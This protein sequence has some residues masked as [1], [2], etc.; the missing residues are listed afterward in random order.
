MQDELHQTSWQLEQAS[1]LPRI[2]AMW[3][4][5]A[6]WLV[7]AQSGSLAYLAPLMI[8]S[9]LLYAGVRWALTPKASVQASLH[10]LRIRVWG[11]WGS[12][13]DVDVPWEEVRRL[14]LAGH[15]R[16]LWV[17]RTDGAFHKVL[18]G[19][20]AH[21]RYLRAELGRRAAAVTPLSPDERDRAEQAIAQLDAVGHARSVTG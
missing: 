11:L 6:A 12:T 5:A 15:D 19:R 21:L 20:P 14:H 9:M 1:V 7:L 18:D 13:L 4:F 2:H 3:L 16:H 10:R 17:E 8:T